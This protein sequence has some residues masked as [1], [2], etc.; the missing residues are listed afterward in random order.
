VFDRCSRK[1]LASA[2]LGYDWNIYIYIYI[3]VGGGGD[4]RGLTGNRTTGTVRVTAVSTAR[5]TISRVM[6]NLSNLEYV[7]SSSGST[8]AEERERQRYSPHT[9][10]RPHMTRVSSC[11]R[12]SF[13]PV[14]I[15][16]YNSSL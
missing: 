13:L 11:H 5:R 14:A 8:W 12:R 10:H 2:C 3:K 7:W 6:S 4:E 15:K 1:N 16:L 9:L